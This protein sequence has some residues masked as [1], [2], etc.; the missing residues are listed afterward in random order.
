MNM[1]LV[2][3]LN[4]LGIEDYRVEVVHDP[5]NPNVMGSLRLQSILRSKAKKIA[6][7]KVTVEVKFTA[8]LLSDPTRFDVRAWTFQLM[9]SSLFIEV[10]EKWDDAVWVIRMIAGSMGFEYVTL[11][12][13]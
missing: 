12:K 8:R 13:S 11:V 6:A 7:S 9:Q 4:D 3:M 10:T 5:A 1:A 2:E